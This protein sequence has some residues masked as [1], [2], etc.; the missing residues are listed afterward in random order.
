[1]ESKAKKWTKVAQVLQDVAEMAVSFKRSRGYSLP[2]FEVNQTS[3][4]SSKNP[5]S[6][7]H[8]S[9]NKLHMKETQQPQTKP[10]KL[11][12]WQC[13]GDHVKKDCPIVTS[14]SRSKH[15]RLLDNKEKQCKLFKSFQKK[16]QN[17]KGIVNEIA[18]ASDDDSSFQS[19]KN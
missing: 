14:Q 17:K 15:S 2:S 5:T 16:I 6:Y 3:T 10:K 11:K 9:T 4:Y 1:M 12:C 18:K 8:H 13:Q 7:Q 19:S